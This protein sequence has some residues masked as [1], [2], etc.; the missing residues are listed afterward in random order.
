MNTSCT[1]IIRIDRDNA[2]VDTTGS[3]YESTHARLM[4][5]QEGDMSLFETK[6]LFK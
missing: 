6:L 2:N 4:C 1:L 5:F 3:A